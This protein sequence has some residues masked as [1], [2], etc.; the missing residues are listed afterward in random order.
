M[1][2][3]PRLRYNFVFCLIALLAL[4]IGP[5]GNSLAQ[6]GAPKDEFQPDLRVATTS[7]VNEVK[8]TAQAGKFTGNNVYD[9][10]GQVDEGQ[11]G[12][13][14]PGESRV[15]LFMLQND[16]TET[17]EI[18]VGLQRVDVPDAARAD[19]PFTASLH[20]TYKKNG[21]YFRDED[22]TALAADSD[23]RVTLKAKRKVVMW[24][25]VAMAAD[26][27][28]DDQG[29]WELAATSKG[30]RKR[31]ILLSAIPGDTLR[32]A[33]RDRYFVQ[34]GEASGPDAVDL[35][36]VRFAHLVGGYPAR[37]DLANWPITSTMGN[38][39][40]SPGK[41]CVPHSKMSQWP[42]A[43]DVG[44]R[45]TMLE[46]NPWIIA[47]INGQ[48]WAGFWEW[49]L[50]AGGDVCKTMS[51]RPPASTTASEMAGHIKAGP[52]ATWKPK[53]GDKVWFF[54][55]S[56]AWPGIDTARE[57]TQVVGPIEWP[58]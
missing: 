50:G 26:M 53:K 58:Y 9:D 25:E 39:T 31:E 56:L 23:L 54:I 22:L 35:N 24:F 16:G 48:L 19:D 4:A 28:D 47:E 30:A 33:T 14:A 6:S 40:I 12:E 11:I 51:S 15:Y 5:V 32:A 27:A 37:V 18:I 29:R 52:F 49:M 13:S 8:G 57:R 45:P 17:D 10:L 36:T 41:I 42:D 20:T 7:Q 46:G 1:N 2:Y 21:K 43:P 55:T 44:G 38:V 34:I 3:V